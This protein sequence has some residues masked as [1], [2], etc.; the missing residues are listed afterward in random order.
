MIRVNPS[1]NTEK[2]VLGLIYVIVIG[3]IVATLILK[4][5]CVAKDG[6][7]FGSGLFWAILYVFILLLLFGLLYTMTINVYVD[8]Y[9]IATIIVFLFA[10]FLISYSCMSLINLGVLVILLLYLMFLFS[11]YIK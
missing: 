6:I 8:G 4:S 7:T 5:R 10:L 11:A 3:V 1:T 2:G 9:M